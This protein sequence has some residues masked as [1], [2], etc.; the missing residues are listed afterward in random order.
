LRF[1]CNPKLD[2][3][4]IRFYRNLG[5]ID[6]YDFDLRHRQ[7]RYSFDYNLRY[8]RGCLL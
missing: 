6:D 7:C 2:S 8:C 3:S 1:D 5:N 4:P